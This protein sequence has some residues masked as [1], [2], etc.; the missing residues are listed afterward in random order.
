[1]RTVREVSR[2][3][4]V[5]V[6]TLHYYDKIGLLH[7]AQVTEAG[8]RL[9]DDTDLE[10]LQS[11]LLFRELQFPLKEIRELLDSPD[12]DRGKALEQQITLLKLQKEHLENLIEL[13]CKIKTTGVRYLDFKAF[14]TSKIDEYTAQARAAWGNTGAYHEYEEKIRNCTQ[15]DIREMNSGMTELFCGFGRLRDTSPGDDAAQ[16]QVKKLQDYITE[17]FYTCTKEILYGLGEMYIGDARFAENI[18]NVGGTG[19]AEFASR[20]IAVYCGISV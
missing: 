3:T 6:R 12:F 5:S 14:D 8:Y 17:H 9:Y 11:V 15:D 2:L 16:R 1:M 4:G 10:R 19:T 13:A 20:A 7:P 18:D